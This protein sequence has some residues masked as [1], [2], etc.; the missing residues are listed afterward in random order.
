MSLQE[1]KVAQNEYTDALVKY[2]EEKFDL[3]NA[4]AEIIIG[5][6]D[7][8][9]QTERDA[10]LRTRLQGYHDAEHKASIEAIKKRG[11]FE[12]A[13]RQHEYNIIEAQI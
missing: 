9:N 6:V 5:G 3:K 1:L 10:Q 8:K 4:E 11:A 12:N 13:S 7:G 2:A